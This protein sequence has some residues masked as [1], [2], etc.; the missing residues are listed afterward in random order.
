[1]INELDQFLV[2]ELY[3]LFNK[4][5]TSDITW[6][7]EYCNKHD[8]NRV[9]ELGIGTG[10]GSYSNGEVWNRSVGSRQVIEHVE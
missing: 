6:Y 10:T 3:D 4:E 7:I 9:L 2:P 1:M 8:F 5:C